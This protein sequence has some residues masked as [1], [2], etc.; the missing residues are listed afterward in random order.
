M[1]NILVEE[2]GNYNRVEKS[3]NS[4]RRSIKN[5][6]NITIKVFFIS[7]SY[8]QKE[9]FKKYKICEIKEMKL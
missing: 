3:K 1:Y 4:I 9:E 5:E 2:E 7:L 8:L 6:M